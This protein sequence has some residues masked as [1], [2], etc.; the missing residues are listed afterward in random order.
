[1]RRSLGHRMIAPG[2]L[3]SYLDEL[4]TGGAV[5]VANALATR[6]ASTDPARRSGQ[7]PSSRRASS[8]SDPDGAESPHRMAPS[9]TRSNVVYEMGNM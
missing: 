9:S 3:N 2:R 4:E 5:T 1:M 7:H 8:R 6:P